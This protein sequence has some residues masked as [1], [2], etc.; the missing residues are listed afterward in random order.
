[1]RPLADTSFAP[2]RSSLSLFF[3]AMLRR[4]VSFSQ[5]REMRDL[6]SEPWFLITDGGLAVEE[7]NGHRNETVRPF[8]TCWA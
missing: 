7:R 5:C 8:G 2:D 4:G 6:E 1:M 3:G